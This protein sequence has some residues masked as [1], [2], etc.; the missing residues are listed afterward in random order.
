[1]RGLSQKKGTDVMTAPSVMAKPGAKATIEIIREFIYPT[2]YEPPELPN[3]VGGNVGAGN[4]VGGG[5]TTFPVTPATPT[6]FETKNTGVTLEIEP[7]VGAND[8]V[9]DLRFA[10]QIV[11]FEGFINYGSPITSPATN[12]LGNPTQVTITENRIEMPVF[13]VRRVQTGITIYDGYTVAVGGLMREDV[14]NVE[15]KV[16]VL[17]DLP[18]IGRLFQSKAENHIKSNLIIFVTAEIIDATGT[19]VKGGSSSSEVVSTFPGGASGSLL[20]AN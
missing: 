8:S 16:P 3:A 13:S 5:G 6:T 12:A 15:D 19:R 2:E 11:E 4:L 14:Q 1:M 9:I 20:P 17:G 10:P 7:N 18:F